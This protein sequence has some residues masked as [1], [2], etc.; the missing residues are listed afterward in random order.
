MEM[1]ITNELLSGTTTLTKGKQAVWALLP[2]SQ[3][4]C[5]S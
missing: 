5:Q 3:L 4:E 1:T 2:G